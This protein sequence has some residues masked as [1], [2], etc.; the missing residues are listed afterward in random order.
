MPYRL[1]TFNGSN[2]SNHATTT[3]SRKNKTGIINQDRNSLAG[4][5]LNFRHAILLANE[6]EV[7]ADVVELADTRD[8]GSRIE[9]YA[10]S[11]LVI[12]I[13]IPQ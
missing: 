6:T 13:F 4:R 1:S 10:S 11:S 8:L 2:V 5:S 12:R 9:R 3:E 7:N